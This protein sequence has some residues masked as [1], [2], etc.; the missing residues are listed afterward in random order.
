MF[1]MFHSVISPT[2]LYEKS[3]NPKFLVVSVRATSV[4]LRCCVVH[5]VGV[6]YMTCT[7]ASYEKLLLISAIRSK[8]LAKRSKCL[9]SADDVTNKLCA[10]LLL[11][12]FAAFAPKNMLI[13]LF[14]KQLKP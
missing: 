14:V 12:Q 13:T 1:L 3:K 4:A 7:S 10:R 8:V 5:P 2:N 9:S 6:V 11:L